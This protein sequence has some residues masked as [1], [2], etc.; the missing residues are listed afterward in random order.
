MI[1]S[2]CSKN[3]S[4]VNGLF[5]AMF[6]DMKLPRTFNVI[7]LD[8][9]WLAHLVSRFACN[10]RVIVDASSKPLVFPSQIE[11]RKKLEPNQHGIKQKLNVKSS[12]N[13]IV[14]R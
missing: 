7:L 4:E 12:I 10:T 13:Q 8:L 1:C 9:G 11:V 3:S 5:G 6:P 2:R 14:I